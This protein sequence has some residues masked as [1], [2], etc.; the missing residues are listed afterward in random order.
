MPFP[1]S[2]ADLRCPVDQGILER[3]A[4]PSG[5]VEMGEGEMPDGGR[6]RVCG[7]CKGILFTDEKLLRI[8]R[9]NGID[10]KKA[11]GRGA[12]RLGCPGCRLDMLVFI[13]GG[14]EIDIC[15]LC[16]FVWMDD[17]EFQK[18]KAVLERDASDRERMLKENRVPHGSG[19]GPFDDWFRSART[20]NWDKT[21]IIWDVLWMLIRAL[22]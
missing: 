16:A 8:V 17:G 18:T 9:N 22:R 19:D 2:P 13:V 12:R 4:P 7:G 14:I 10:V 20:D 5:V 11:M 6:T 3:P 1:A 21:D 15:P